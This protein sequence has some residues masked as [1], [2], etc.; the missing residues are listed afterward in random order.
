MQGTFSAAEDILRG[1]VMV[2]QFY[3]MCCYWAYGAI[4][5]TLNFRIL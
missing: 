4:H 3:D 1:Q 2:V 5:V